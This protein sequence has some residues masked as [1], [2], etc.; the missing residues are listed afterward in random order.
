MGVETG[1]LMVPSTSLGIDGS[2]KA[3][4]LLMA[5][6]LHVLGTAAVRQDRLA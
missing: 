4:E 5:M 2:G 1:R 3:D 6:A